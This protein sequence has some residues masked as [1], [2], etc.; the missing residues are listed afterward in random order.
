MRPDRETVTPVGMAP[1]KSATTSTLPVGMT[2]ASFGSPPLTFAPVI[3]VRPFSALSSHGRDGL[4]QPIDPAVAATATIS[5]H[6]FE[7]AIMERPGG[8]RHALR[9]RQPF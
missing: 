7:L 9:D 4:L 8:K 1:S 5:R 3:S 6:L 2:V